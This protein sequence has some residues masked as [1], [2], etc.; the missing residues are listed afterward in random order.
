MCKKYNI[1]Q[2]TK[3]HYTYEISL[4]EGIIKTIKPAY[5]ESS[6]EELLKRSLHGKT[7]NPMNISVAACGKGYEKLYS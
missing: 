5:R 2:S 7:Q 4:P 3:I 6:K 1:A